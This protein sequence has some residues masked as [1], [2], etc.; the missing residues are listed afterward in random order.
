ME[1]VQIERNDQSDLEFEGELIATD[2]SPCEGRFRIF[3]TLAGRYVLE[4]RKA[5]LRGA[6]I[7]RVCTYESVSELLKSLGWGPA[8]KRLAA[9]LGVPANEKID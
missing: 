5:A 9:R 4:Q 3:R 8:A 1:R 2:A 6:P 7:H